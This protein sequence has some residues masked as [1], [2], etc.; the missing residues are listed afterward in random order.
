M[1]TYVLAPLAG[2]CV[3][4]SLEYAHF[5]TDLP[6]LR[7][8]RGRQLVKAPLGTGTQYTWY[9]AP[10]ARCHTVDTSRAFDVLDDYTRSSTTVDGKYHSLSMQGLNQIVGH[11]VVSSFLHMNAHTTDEVEGEDVA[12]GEG[13]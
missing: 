13:G 11:A 8:L 7:C 3:L 9:G 4:S 2:E 10:D 1:A 6:S 5:H 12:G